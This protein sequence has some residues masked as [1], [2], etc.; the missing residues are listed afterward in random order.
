WTDSL[1][2]RYNALHANGKAKSCRSQIRNLAQNIGTGWR[3]ELLRTGGVV[4]P[5]ADCQTGRVGTGLMLDTQLRAALPSAAPRPPASSSAPLPLG[6]R[7]SL[8]RPRR[9]SSLRPTR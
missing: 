5:T 3:T 6:T 1:H 4:A 9:S 8:R 7:T 2:I